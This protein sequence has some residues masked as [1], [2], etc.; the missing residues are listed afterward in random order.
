MQKKGLA[1]L[2]SLT[3]AHSVPGHEDEV[4]EIF[5]NELREH[6]ELGCDKVGSVYCRKGA[7]GPK[8]MVEGHMDEVGFRVQSI[9]SEWI[10]S[11]WFQLVVGGDIPCCP[12]GLR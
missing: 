7:S 11:R 9:P 6:G 1:L 4:R 8:V 5:V 3:Q 12:S 2:K 10:F